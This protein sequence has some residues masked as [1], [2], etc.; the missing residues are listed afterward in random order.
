MVLVMELLTARLL[1]FVRF[2]SWFVGYQFARNILYT[3]AILV[4]FCLFSF[5]FLSRNYYAL[6]MLKRIALFEFLN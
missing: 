6:K 4:I 2:S 1:E 5:F 3:L